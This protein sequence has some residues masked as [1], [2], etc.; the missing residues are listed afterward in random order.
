MFVFSRQQSTLERLNE[1]IM[2]FKNLCAILKVFSKNMCV[3]DAISVE[4]SSPIRDS[5]LSEHEG[6]TVFVCQNDAT[7]TPRNGKVLLFTPKDEH[8][9][10]ELVKRILLC[11]GRGRRCEQPAKQQHVARAGQ[12]R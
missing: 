12:L 4:A 8:G 2:N 5:T 3:V 10:S 6:V 1:Q 9:G 7:S 11:G